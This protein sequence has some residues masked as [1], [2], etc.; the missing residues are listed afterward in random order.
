MIKLTYPLPNSTAKVAFA[1][2]DVVHRIA[3]TAKHSFPTRLGYWSYLH[4]SSSSR[5]F[6]SR[7]MHQQWVPE[8]QNQLLPNPCKSWFSNILFL[9]I[10]TIQLAGMLLEIVSECRIKISAQRYIREHLVQFAC[11]FHTTDFL[12]IKSIYLSHWIIWR[13]HHL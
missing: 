4:P 11:V 12:S 2:C 8:Y 5:P 13:Q 10:L 3:Q 9:L 1:H 6:G 7:A